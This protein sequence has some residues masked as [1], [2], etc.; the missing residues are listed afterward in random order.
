M[1]DVHEANA[2]LTCIYLGFKFVVCA[3]VLQTLSVHTLF[4]G[5]SQ[6]LHRVNAYILPT[7]IYQSVNCVI[8]GRQPFHESRRLCAVL[9]PVRLFTCG[10]SARALAAT[11]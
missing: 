2:Q 9:V 6:F 8:P 11:S 1:P 5:S 7:A 4:A 10:S 3:D